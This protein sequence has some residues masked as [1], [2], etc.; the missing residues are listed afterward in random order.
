MEGKHAAFVNVVGESVS[1][2]DEYDLSLK[3]YSDGC[4]L[5]IKCAFEDSLTMALLVF[6]VSVLNAIALPVLS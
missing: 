1:V 6:S 5:V 3:K 2:K 4:W